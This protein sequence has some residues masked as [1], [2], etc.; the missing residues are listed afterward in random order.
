MSEKIKIKINLS[1]VFALC[2][3]SLFAFTFFA[4]IFSYALVEGDS[5]IVPCGYDGARSS[6]GKVDLNVP[7]SMRTNPKEGALDP[8]EECNFYDFVTTINVIIQGTIVIISIYAAISFMYAGYAYLT[9]G[10]SQEK[11]SYAKGIFK[12][13][14][15]GY[16]IILSAWAFVKLIED[17]MLNAQF[18]K[19]NSFLGTGNPELPECK[20][21]TN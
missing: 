9:S 15:L 17:A 19:C 6:G 14:L 1:K 4:P 5:R 10:G 11:V 21:W 7:A 20:N 12:K 8:N 3:L 18:I 13:V 16:I 2:F